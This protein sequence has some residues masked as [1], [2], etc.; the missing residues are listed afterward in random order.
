[1]KI[2]F[3]SDLHNDI[4]VLENLLEK[5]QGVFYCLGDS[6]LSEDQLDK[7]KINSVLGNCDN[8][9]LPLELVLNIDDKKILLVHGHKFNVKYN[10]NNLYFYSKSMD[11]DYVIYGHTHIQSKDDNL[12]NPGSLKN[13]TYLIYE[14]NYFKFMRLE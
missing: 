12:Y 4:K 10:L 5:E 7:Y 11:C 3:F 2:I 14:N 1:M 6:K 9:D 8:I 13:K